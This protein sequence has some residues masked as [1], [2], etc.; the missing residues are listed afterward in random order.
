MTTIIVAMTTN[1]NLRA[2]SMQHTITCAKAI[3]ASQQEAWAVWSDLEA[4][5]K[6]DPRE[7]LNELSGP[8][9]VGTTGTFKQRGRGAGQYRI[10]ALEPGTA[11]TSETA[12]PGGKLVIEHLLESSPKGVTLTKRYTAHGP[13]ALAFRW[14]FARE[15]EREV[16]KS[17]AALENEIR[18]RFSEEKA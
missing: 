10:T 7:E 11:W 13:L 4:Y 9:A 14:F 8:F 12:L 18:R 2:N 1:S 15:I 5:P 17:F 3:A 16:P 6:W